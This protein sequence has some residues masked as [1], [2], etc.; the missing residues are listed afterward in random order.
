M[1]S[2]GLENEQ[3]TIDAARDGDRA[4]FELIVRAYSGAIYQY[5]RNVIGDAHA[6]EDVSQR[7]FMN[8]YGNLRRYDPGRGK[9][10]TWIF[11]IARNAALNHLRDTKRSA[12]PPG[13][14]AAASEL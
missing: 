8:V 14:A 11:R 2:S 10:G 7:V 5:V 12:M 9:F 4:A 13:N 1:G 3:Q 6:T